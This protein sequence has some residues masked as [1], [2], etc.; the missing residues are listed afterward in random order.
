[1]MSITLPG[2]L[3]RCR[4]TAEPFLI[5]VRYGGWVRATALDVADTLLAEPLG[6]IRIWPSCPYVW[7]RLSAGWFSFDGARQPLD[8]DPAVELDGA[9]LEELTFAPEL[10]EWPGSE[11]GF[12]RV[13]VI[14]G[15]GCELPEDD[16]TIRV[17]P[18]RK[19]ALLRDA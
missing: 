15:P 8:D 3:I 10:C 12:K 18:G 9:A 7:F 5:A 16:P 19:P 4:W 1:M 14:R 17:L 13:R 11:G 6:S 2:R